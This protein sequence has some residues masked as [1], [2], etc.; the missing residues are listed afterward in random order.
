MVWRWAGWSAGIVLLIVSGPGAAAAAGIGARRRDTAGGARVGA[1][2][3]VVAGRAGWPQW[4]A[5]DLSDP[6]AAR[7]GGLV[8]TL[9]LP[10]GGERPGSATFRLGWPW[11]RWRWCR[12]VSSRRCARPGGPGPARRGG[13]SCWERP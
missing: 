9:A 8:R 12:R 7:S 5:A 13:S 3:D 2:W 6:A 1:A 10:R 4:Q 11:G